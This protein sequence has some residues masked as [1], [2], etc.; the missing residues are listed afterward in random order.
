MSPTTSLL[1]VLL[2]PSCGSF[3]RR[4]V[5][6]SHAARARSAQRQT[7]WRARRHPI[8]AAA[9]VVPRWTSRD[10]SAWPNGG[11]TRSH[12]PQRNCARHAICTRAR[13]PARVIGCGCGR[14]SD[15]PRRF[16]SRREVHRGTTW[17]AATIR[18]PPRLPDRLLLRGRA[19]A[20]CPSVTALRSEGTHMA[21]PG[22]HMKRLVVGIIAAAVLVLMPRTAM[23]QTKTVT[24][25]M[26]TETATVEA[27]EA[28]TRT[29]TLKKA[30]GTVRD[31]RRRA[32]HHAV[33][34]DQGRRQGH[35]QVLR[36]RRRPAEAARRAGRGERRRRARL[37]PNRPCR[38]AP[39]PS[40]RRS[41]PR[42]RPST[43]TRRRSPSP[44]RTAGST[45]PKCRTRRLS[46]R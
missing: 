22:G 40:R 25:E 32:G 31:D 33:R 17:A 36:E 45:R 11:R 4:A 12:S 34:G 20:A 21:G 14:L 24:S 28:S 13:A 27:I 30:D 42:S 37:V 2:I 1:Y 10:R 16:R 18:L 46:P 38:V 15:R 26:R 23:A 35:R 6:A 9:H 5:T 41:R 43:R 8:V 3:H 29:V 19:R 39:K 44:G 7:V